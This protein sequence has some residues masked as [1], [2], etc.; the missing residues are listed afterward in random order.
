MPIA[1]V[2]FDEPPSE[3]QPVLVDGNSEHAQQQRRPD[4]NA[5]DEQQRQQRAVPF[6]TD[7]VLPVWT[8]PCVRWE[9]WAESAGADAAPR[10]SPELLEAFERTHPPPGSMIVR[11]CRALTLSLRDCLRA[12]P[13]CALVCADYG[14]AELA[15]AAHLSHDPALIAALK[16]PGDPFEQIARELRGRPSARPV[17]RDERDRAK[18]SCYSMLYGGGSPDAT[19]RFFA[20]FPQLEKLIEALRERCQRPG[21]VVRT[22]A[23]RARHFSEQER[24]D[25]TLIRRRALNAVT[26]GSVADLVKMAMIAND[27][28]EGRL[29]AAS[30]SATLRC[31]LL[32]HLHDELVY[33]VGEPALGALG[34]PTAAAVPSGTPPCDP[35]VLRLAV[36]GILEGMEG[37][38]ARARL[39]APL[40]VKVKV[41]VR[42]G[43]VTDYPVSL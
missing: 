27:S 41:G 34:A 9:E 1:L 3:A 36:R 5:D 38:G 31:R 26:Q 17:E 35:D 42:W 7:R 32:M 16:Q 37:V 14:N 23:G 4:A 8:F 39:L 33:E 21:G 15:I 30:G 29:R 20:S 28:L 13:G 24:R 2:R 11:P 25:A 19:R 6:P 12:R 22:I 18:R 10:P 43:S 40:R